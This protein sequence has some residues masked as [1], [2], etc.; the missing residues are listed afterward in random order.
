MIDNQAA[1]VLEHIGISKYVFIHGSIGC[2]QVVKIEVLHIGEQVT[3]VQDREDL[4]GMAADQSLV[5]RLVPFGLAEFH[6]IFFAEALHLS[7]TEHGQARQCRQHYCDT[8]VFVPVAKLLDGRLLIRVAHKV[9]IAL[10]DLRVE[11]ERVLDR[12]AVFFVVLV[13]QHMHERRIVDPVHAQGTDKIA[14]EQPEGFRQE[15]SIGDLRSDPV[16]DIAPEL[17]RDG[18]VE[19]GAGQAMLRA[20]W[21]GA[22]R[23][24]FREP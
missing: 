12:Q 5:R 6:P 16:Y 13:A 14:L 15:Q 1:L 20:G 19:L 8:K 23:T 10:E 7:V 24:G 18:G 3:T 2:E 4:P 17:V 9:D 22:A 21:D 11:L